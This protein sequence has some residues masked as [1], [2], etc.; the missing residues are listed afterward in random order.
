M[1]GELECDSFS[2]SELFCFAWLI[3]HF[4]RI[5]S[6]PAPGALL[7]S[8]AIGAAHGTVAK[9]LVIDQRINVAHKLA[10]RFRQ[11]DDRHEGSAKKS[12]V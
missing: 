10:A 6:V 9:L 12:R 3:S 5:K 7:Y 2:F 4:R 8:G 11:R 1:S